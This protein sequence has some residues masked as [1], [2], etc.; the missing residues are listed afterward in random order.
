MTHLAFITKKI[1][2]FLHEKK[3]I[4]YTVSN[5]ENLDS[6]EY[7]HFIKKKKKIF[8]NQYYIRIIKF[9]NKN[10]SSSFNIP[11]LYNYAEKKNKFLKIKK[12]NF[13]YENHQWLTYHY[14]LVEKNLILELIKKIK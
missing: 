4:L 1:F 9:F 5:L 13:L 3:V 2:D 6:G 8:S 10:R 11:E 14:Y 7:D 12:Y